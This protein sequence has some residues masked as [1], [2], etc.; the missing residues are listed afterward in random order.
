VATTEFQAFVQ[1]AYP[2]LRDRLDAET[3]MNTGVCV[4]IR[5]TLEFENGNAGLDLRGLRGGDRP[6]AFRRSL[7]SCARRDLPELHQAL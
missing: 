5:L 3:R 4:S 1:L 7:G 2:A 6:G